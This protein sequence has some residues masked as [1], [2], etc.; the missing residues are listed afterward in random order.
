MDRPGLALI[1]IFAA[2]TVRVR[3]GG[4]LIRR[5]VRRR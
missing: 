5:R 3:D 1:V 2:F 4:E